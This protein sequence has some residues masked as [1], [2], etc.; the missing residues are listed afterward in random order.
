MSNNHRLAPLAARK[1]ASIEHIS[2]EAR[3]TIANIFDKL[4]DARIKKLLEL[5]AGDLGQL[6]ITDARPDRTAGLLTQAKIESSLYKV[7]HGKIIC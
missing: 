7:E 5:T 2:S 3:V 6:F 1:G 4:D